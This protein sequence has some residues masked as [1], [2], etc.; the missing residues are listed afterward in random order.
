MQDIYALKTKCEKKEY[1]K[2]KIKEI[3]KDIFLMQNC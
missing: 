3:Y 2:E 1:D